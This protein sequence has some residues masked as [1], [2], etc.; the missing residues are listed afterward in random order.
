[1]SQIGNRGLEGSSQPLLQL[2]ASIRQR[3]SMLLE[4]QQKLDLLKDD[5]QYN[6]KLIEARDK[7]I[8]R[9]EE[10][11][12]GYRKRGEEMEE[13]IKS[14]SGKIEVLQQKEVERQEKV[15]QDKLMYKVNSSSYSLFLLICLSISF[16]ILIV[17]RSF[18]HL[19]VI[20]VM[21]L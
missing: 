5:F 4:T 9:L 16:S 14:L 11:V 17:D 6:L 20:V 15:E 8:E 10:V 7:E 12:I 21:V 2:E 18:I 3:E 19:F 1:M 13:K